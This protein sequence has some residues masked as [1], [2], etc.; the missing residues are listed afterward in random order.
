MGSVGV[1]GALLRQQVP[2]YLV[3]GYPHVVGAGNIGIVYWTVLLSPLIKL[4]KAILLWDLGNDA[5]DW[6]AFLSS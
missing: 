1:D 6:V 4:D 2:S 3:G 5:N